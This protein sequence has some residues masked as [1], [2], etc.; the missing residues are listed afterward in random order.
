MLLIS[1]QSTKT[2]STFFLN[3]YNQ[4]VLEIDSFEVTFR[5]LRKLT[6]IM[7]IKGTASH[8]MIILMATLCLL[9]I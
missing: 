1:L 8:E 9:L 3:H 5:C 6:S 2:G 4:T 7:Q